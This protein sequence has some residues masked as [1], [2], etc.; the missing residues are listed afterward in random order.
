MKALLAAKRS[1]VCW[2]S[3]MCLNVGG[4]SFIYCLYAAKIPLCFCRLSGLFTMN[5]NVFGLCVR[6]DFRAQ[7]F[8]LLLKFIRSTKLQ[9]CTSP[10]L[11]QNPCYVP[12]FLSFQFHHFSFSVSCSSV[13]VS[14]KYT[15]HLK[16]YKTHLS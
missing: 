4:V 3:Q 6:A 5:A 13:G 16:T 11:T 7:S 10:R 14:A 8:N 2:G 9:V 1:P 12:F 15:A